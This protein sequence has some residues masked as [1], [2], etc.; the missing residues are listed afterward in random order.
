MKKRRIAAVALLTA[1]LLAALLLLVHRHMAA[2]KD[3]TWDR[4]QKSGVLRVG[5]DP[6]F[7]PFEADDGKG[8]IAGLDVDLARSLAESLG[9]SA[10]IEPIGF[11]SL[12]DALWTKRVDVVI[13]AMPM[14]YTKSKDVTYSQPYFDAGQYLVIRRGETGIRSTG[15]LKGRSLAVEWGSE[16]DALARQIRTKMPE[17][18]L[19]L[20][21][22]PKAALQAVVSGE[23]DA[24]LVDGVSARMFSGPICVLTPSVSPT[25]YVVVMPK[26][27]PKL[28]K[29][30]DQ[31]L[32]EMRRSGALQALVRKWMYPPGEDPEKGCPSL[33]K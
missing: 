31:A 29:A 20:K 27:A 25:P 30:V 26:H 28:S 5:L 21:E 13:S 16:G 32:E 14:D 1:G 9:V 11:D 24:A 33:E 10:K 15:D 8:G 6:S 19:V 4:V 3:P 18:R 12:L 22:D 7:P 2:S 23:A 17:M